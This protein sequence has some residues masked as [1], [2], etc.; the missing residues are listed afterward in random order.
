M[1][2][3][4]CPTAEKGSVKTES[5]LFALTALPFY[6]IKFY[7][8]K[9]EDFRTFKDVQKVQGAP[10]DCPYRPRRHPYADFYAGGHRSNG[11]GGNASTTER[12]HQGSDYP[13]KHVP[14]VL[15]PDNAQNCGGRWH[16]QVHELGRPCAYGQRR[17]PGVEF[18]RPSQNQARRR[19]IQEHSGRFQAFL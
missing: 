2:V 8:C 1:T 5:F 11:Q 16:P 10:R 4:V 9:H 13:R 17:I 15:A 7:I 18:E 3:Q 12:R 14:L 6:R 19:G